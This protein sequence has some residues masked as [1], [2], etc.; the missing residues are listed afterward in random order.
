[1]DI[2]K[3][4]GAYSTGIFVLPAFKKSLFIQYPCITWL[5]PGNK[6]EKNPAFPVLP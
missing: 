1:M 6:N 2:N 5:K 3:N 4:T